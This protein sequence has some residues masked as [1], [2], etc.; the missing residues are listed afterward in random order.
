M[1]KITIQE[2]AEK[3]DL[4][5][6]TL[7]YYEKEGLI[8]PI[9]KNQSGIREYREEDLNRIEFVKCMRG[10]GLS[11]SVLKEYIRLYDE[12]DHTKND[13]IKLLEHERVLLKEKIECMKEA[14]RKLEY[15]I[16]YY[17]SGDGKCN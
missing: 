9:L 3:Y 12:G 7:R 4:N 13:R 15:K 2:V 5:K 1:I 6:D 16:N 17:K 10:A 8:G 14:Y 11:I